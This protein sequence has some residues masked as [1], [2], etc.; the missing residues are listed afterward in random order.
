MPRRYLDKNSLSVIIII[1]TEERM[2]GYKTLLQ[3]LFLSVQR[4]KEYVMAREHGEKVIATNKKARHDYF[5]EQTMEAGIVLA[6]TEVKSI[7]QGKVNLRDSYAEVLGNEIFLHNMHIG[8]YE[9]GNIFNRDPDRDRKLLLH[10][11]EINRLIG[12]SQQKGLSLV[13]LRVYFRDGRVKVELAVAQGKK[14]YDKRRDIAKRD[15]NREIDRK[16]KEHINK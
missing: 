6:G 11:H 2:H 8:P 14:Q 5:I 15:A 3:G 4:W 1:A 9:K 16:L 7:R 13:P 12:Y 10:R